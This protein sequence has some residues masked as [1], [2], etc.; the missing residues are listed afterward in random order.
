MDIEL[1]NNAETGRENPV[2]G[3]YQHEVY[4]E[5]MD[6]FLERHGEK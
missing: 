6:K 2:D 3:Q 4:K 1:I 5:A